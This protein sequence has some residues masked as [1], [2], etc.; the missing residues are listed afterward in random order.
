MES[1]RVGFANKILSQYGLILGLVGA[2]V[3]ILA[4]WL[5]LGRR[6][7]RWIWVGLGLLGT[8][9]LVLLY[10]FVLPRAFPEVDPGLPIFGRH[11]WT[12]M[13]A[14]TA[15][16]IAA[17]FEIVRLRRRRGVARS[18]PEG[19]FPD[20]DAAWEAIGL[21]LAQAR[22]ELA[23]QRV[24]LL[25][26]LDEESAA[27]Q[28]R[29]AG[30]QPFAQGPDGPSP[31]H[32]F[33]LAEGILLSCAGASG[34]GGSASEGPARL[35]DLCHKL[36]AANPDAPMLGGVVLLLPAD[37]ATEAE[38][39]RRAAVVRDDLQVIRHAL[40]V[41]PPV[42]AIVPQMERV[43]G[44]R[45]FVARLAEPM[46]Q[47][48]CGF[49]VPGSQT[50]SGDLVQRGLAW[51]TGWFETWTLRQMADDPLNQPG[52]GRLFCLVDEVRRRRPRWRA[53]VEAALSTHRDAEPVH[54][55]G[56][57][58]TATGPGPDERA[59]SAGL[60][61][62]ARS[63]V[64]ADHVMAA[65]SDEAVAED[66]VYRRIALGVGSIGGALVLLAWMFIIRL[67]PLG[68]IGFLSILIVWIIVGVRLALR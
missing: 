18:A 45:E 27:S 1:G 10:E 65:W 39:A 8:V 25:L 58:C 4:G 17:G 33:A 61:R 14:F 52:N 23:E 47:S 3:A 68:W 37:W 20:L 38:S 26:A 67:Y 2:F 42:F 60:F 40:K 29:A 34:L 44:L 6:H 48:R 54:F 64:L 53:V 51:L 66:R 24:Y 43:V 57:Y 19:R 36:R 35:E 63:R 32:A 50:F 12:W 28:V 13:L 49:A 7:T 21:K 22:I 56:L 30:L 9:G 46:R 55:R 59:F 15:G 41:R 5:A 31:I 16:A 62:G 11:I